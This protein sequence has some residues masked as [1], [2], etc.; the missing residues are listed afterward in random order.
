MLTD[1]NNQ[2]FIHHHSE[3]EA[4]VFKEMN[5]HLPPE[6][7]DGMCSLS[8]ASDMYSYAKFLVEIKNKLNDLRMFDSI[9]SSCQVSFPA[10]CPTATQVVETLMHCDLLVKH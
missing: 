1:A 2:E 4:K 8:P 7:C 5:P 6:V 9:I 10:H 3:K